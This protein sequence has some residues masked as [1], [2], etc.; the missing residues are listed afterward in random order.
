[1]C[2][3]GAVFDG[4]SDQASIDAL[5]SWK[6]NIVR[7]PINEDCWLGING[8]PAGKLS[9]DA[10]RSTIVAYV[11][12]LTSNGIA[13]IIDLHWAAPGTEPANGQIPMPDAD[14]A[15]AF[16]ASVADTFKGNQSV[17]FDLFNEPF[18][19]NNG[20]SIAAWTCMRD[21]GTCPG[22]SYTAVGTQALVNVIRAQGANNIIMVPGVQFSN[23]LTQW[24]AFK[25]T[26]PQS[27]L[28]AS[29]HS[30]LGQICGNQTCW[31]TNIAPVL[32]Q[33]PVISGEI[34][35]NDC[36]HGYID[37]LMAWL[38]ERGGSYLGWAWNTYDCGGFP[39]LISNFDGTPTNFGIG[40][41]DHL[42]QLG[43]G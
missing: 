19:D 11:N 18:P 30:Y 37:A 38:D 35:E 28:A 27:N 23:S 5:K 41:R 3:G 15:P 32:A 6:V 1:M 20:D 10:Y 34:G 33:V 2:P 42:V 36:Q 22:V 14:H 12:L 31:D 4:P 17:V 40:L 39:A 8:L 9:A 26:D 21:G 16:W 7:I 29:W 24:L 25:P 43:G 13:S